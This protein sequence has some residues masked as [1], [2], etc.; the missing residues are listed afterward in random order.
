MT[1]SEGK[2]VGHRVSARNSPRATTPS[3]FSY[4]A[5]LVSVAKRLNLWGPIQVMPID[6][7][8]GD[9]ECRNRQARNGRFCRVRFGVACHM[10]AWNVL[11]RGH[12][13]WPGQAVVSIKQLFA[14]VTVASAVLRFS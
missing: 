7:A 9:G 1:E 5:R 13:E 8:Q 4:R 14:C 11:S 12:F 10:S 6:W 2:S 3:S